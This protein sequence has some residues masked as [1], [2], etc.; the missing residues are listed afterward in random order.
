[1]KLGTSNCVEENKK[2]VQYT[3]DL[4]SIPNYY[5]KAGR[6]PRAPLREETRGPRV[7]HR[8]FA[9]EEVQKQVLLGYPRPVHTRREVPQEHV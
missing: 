4:L 2:I 6:P 8:Q 1:M 5:I 7:L 3:M 9:Q